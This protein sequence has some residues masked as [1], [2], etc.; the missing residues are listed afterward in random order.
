[1]RTARE[2]VHQFSV[3]LAHPFATPQEPGRRTRSFA[4]CPPQKLSG[5]RPR[6]RPTPGRPI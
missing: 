2:K 3:S 1:M 4:L 6:L 5:Q